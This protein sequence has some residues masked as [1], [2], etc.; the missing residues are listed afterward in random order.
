[1]RQGDVFQ[2]PG[3]DRPGTRDFIMYPLFLIINK[4]VKLTK[5]PMS[6]SFIDT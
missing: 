6:H 1:M 5:T 4:L 2:T 3:R